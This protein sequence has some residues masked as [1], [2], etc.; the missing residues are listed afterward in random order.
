MASAAPIPITNEADIPKS[1]T[2]DGSSTRSAAILT[3]RRVDS[4]FCRR[5]MLFRSDGES[6]PNSS[7]QCLDHVGRVDTATW[8]LVVILVELLLLLLLLLLESAL[9]D[10]ASEVSFPADD[11]EA[12][13]VSVS[14]SLDVADDVPVADICFSSVLSTF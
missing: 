2:A 12:S 14:I 1:A 7:D 11:T 4:N 10:P 6:L 9:S 13:A 8:A 3:M 5:R